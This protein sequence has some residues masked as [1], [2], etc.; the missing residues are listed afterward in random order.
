[1]GPSSM[2]HAMVGHGQ[3][4]GRSRVG[5]LAGPWAASRRCPRTRP[6]AMPW[7]VMGEAV[8]DHGGLGLELG[9]GLGI[10]HGGHHG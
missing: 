5:P 6:W 10:L 2:G 1:M 7:S 3:V 8:V 9:S 4:R